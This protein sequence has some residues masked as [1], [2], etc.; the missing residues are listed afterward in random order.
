MAKYLMSYDYHK[1]RDYTALYA[2]LRHW[3]AARILESLWL[4]DLDGSATA[5]RLDLKNCADAD[6]VFVVIELKPGADWA[7]T[8]GV[9]SAG[10]NWLENNV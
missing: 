1:S 9:Q 10:G 3:G 5:V 2:L 7:F 6:D 4:A 8:A